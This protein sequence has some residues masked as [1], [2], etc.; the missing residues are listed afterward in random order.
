MPLSGD[1]GTRDPTEG[2]FFVHPQHP[3]SQARVERVQVSKE[4]GIR[5]K[6]LGLKGSGLRTTTIQ[7]IGFSDLGRPNWVLG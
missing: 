4:E 7:S 3:Q 6:G 2:H 1:P 5:P